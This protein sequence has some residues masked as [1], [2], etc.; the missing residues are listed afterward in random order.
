M[1]SLS[2]TRRTIADDYLAHA[3]DRLLKAMHDAVH[4]LTRLDRCKAQAKLDWYARE[5]YRAFEVVEIQQAEDRSVAYANT[6]LQFARP[7]GVPTE[8]DMQSKWQGD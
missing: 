2:V 6:V 4:G 8:S 7:W 5:V 3:S 1:T